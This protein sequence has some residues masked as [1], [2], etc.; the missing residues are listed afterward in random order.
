[1]EE[2]CKIIC[3]TPRGEGAEGESEKF[4]L[5]QFSASLG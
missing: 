5:T 1:M 2:E 4:A 3:Y